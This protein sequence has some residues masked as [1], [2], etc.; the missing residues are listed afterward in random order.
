[1][2]KTI[3]LSSSPSST[4]ISYTPVYLS[5]ISTLIVNVSG[6]NLSKPPINI[7]ISWGDN[8]PVYIEY[9][10]FFST[11]LNQVNEIFYGFDYSIIKNYSHIYSPSDT[12]LTKNLTCQALI[13]YFDGT[14]CRFVQPITIY[15]PSFYSRIED[16]HLLQNNIVDNNDKVLFTFL[17]QKDGYVL[18]SLY[19][20]PNI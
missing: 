20:P 15:S 1:M 11:E 17:A 16:L 6:I 2:T 5:D 3:Y 9:N 8:T 7:K 4:Q 13:T 14:S 18:E 19:T 10:K 12:S